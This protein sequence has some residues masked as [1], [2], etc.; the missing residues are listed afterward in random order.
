MRP[1]SDSSGALNR[2]KRGCLGCSEG[3]YVNALDKIQLKAHTEDM[4]HSDSENVPPLLPS[5]SP[6][7]IEASSRLVPHPSSDAPERVKSMEY[8]LTVMCTCW[9][10]WPLTRFL[11]RHPAVVSSNIISLP[12]QHP[13]GPNHLSH[14]SLSFIIIASSSPV[15]YTLHTPFPTNNSSPRIIPARPPRLPSVS[16]PSN[17]SP[18]ACSSLHRHSSARSSSKTPS[19]ASTIFSPMTGKNLKP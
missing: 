7:L 18:S 12:I 3:C 8:Q 19:N 1:E 17:T 11:V 15:N 2:W 9:R 6:I 5:F 13:I 4:R 10:R 14:L 16:A